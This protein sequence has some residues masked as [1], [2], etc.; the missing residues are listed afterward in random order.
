VLITPIYVNYNLIYEVFSQ[1]HVCE[2]LRYKW[3]LQHI[4]LWKFVVF[5]TSRGTSS[6]PSM[7][8]IRD[9]M[10]F[11]LVH[12]TWNDPYDRVTSFWNHKREVA[13]AC[14]K[15]RALWII[16]RLFKFSFTVSRSDGQHSS[17]NYEYLSRL[18]RQNSHS[19][20]WRQNTSWSQF[21]WRMTDKS[22]F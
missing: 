4:Q 18:I 7:N 10:V 13:S 15:T 2:K 8:K 20:Q 11:S 6:L 12:L 3:K 16:K 17:V 5:H 9:G 19:R 1:L 14:I 21:M 22:V